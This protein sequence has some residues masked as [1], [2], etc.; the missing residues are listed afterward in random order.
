MKYPKFLQVLTLAA[1]V[2]TAL[3]ITET[4]V[5][6][7]EKE[8]PKE[9][10]A[11]TEYQLPKGYHY[12]LSDGKYVVFGGNGKALVEK[13]EE[14]KAETKAETKKAALQEEVKKEEPKIAIPAKRNEKE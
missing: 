10:E 11:R 6:A 7:S 13:D 8:T 4:A 1:V 9:Y 12:V 5:Y 14:K 2:T 3:P